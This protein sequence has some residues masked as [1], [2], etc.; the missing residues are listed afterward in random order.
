M[1]DTD[2][3]SHRGIS[4]GTDEGAIT[5]RIPRPTIA[6]ASGTS[7]AAFAGRSFWARPITA[8]TDIQVMLMTLSATSTSISPMLEPT[9]YEPELE[10][11]AGRSRGS[12]GGS[13]A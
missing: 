2:G 12:A 11:G 4:P 13:A 7:M 8:I 6:S 9:Q 5:I 1:A 10:T 3:G